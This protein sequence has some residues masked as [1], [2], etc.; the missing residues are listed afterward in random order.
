MTIKDFG[1]NNFGNKNFNPEGETPVE[2]I[3]F[4]VSKN[5]CLKINVI[6]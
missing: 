5:K 4:F 6:N 1:E 2:L 3:S